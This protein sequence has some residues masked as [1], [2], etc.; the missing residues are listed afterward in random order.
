MA[1]EETARDIFDRAKPGAVSE[2]FTDN[3]IIHRFEPEAL[4]ELRTPQEI[5]NKI[6]RIFELEGVIDVPSIRASIE[7]LAAHSREIGGMGQ[8]DNRGFVGSDPTLP[9]EGYYVFQ[10]VRSVYD[11]DVLRAITLTRTGWVPRAEHCITVEDLQGFQK[12]HDESFG[13]KAPSYI[14]HDMNIMIPPYSS[15]TFDADCFRELKGLVS[16]HEPSSFTGIHLYEPPVISVTAINIP[17]Q[18]TIG[19]DRSACIFSD[20]HHQIPSEQWN[21]RHENVKLQRERNLSELQFRF[22]VSCDAQNVTI[23]SLDRGFVAL[24]FR[25]LDY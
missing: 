13:G 6:M 5:T 25:P 3:V 8:I 11:P 19:V 23:E 18:C 16:S 24:C 22:N 4:A 10:T 12:Q 7:L 1:K 2:Q 21:S 14:P 17:L 15:R 20:M 9:M